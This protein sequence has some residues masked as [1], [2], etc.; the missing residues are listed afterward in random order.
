MLA[1]MT[2]P[3]PISEEEAIGLPGPI[4]ADLLE[5]ATCCEAGAYRGAAL[6]A[7]RAVEQ[8]VVMRRVPLEMKTLH[9]KL[10]WLLKAG[11]LPGALAGD[12]R[13]VR[14]LGNAASHGAEALTRDEAYAM[15][16]S[17]LAVARGVLLPA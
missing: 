6:L 12:A 8:V 4:V 10:V 5:A 2:D 13:M 9:Q 16:A 17:S 7:R 15:V 1:S 3:S 14:D 11:H